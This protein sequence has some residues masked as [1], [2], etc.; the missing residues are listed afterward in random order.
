MV[1]CSSNRTMVWSSLC[2]DDSSNALL[3]IFVTSRPSLS[4]LLLHLFLFLAPLSVVSLL[5]AK[6]LVPL[7]KST[8]FWFAWFDNSSL[9][10]HALAVCVHP[11]LKHTFLLIPKWSTVSWKWSLVTYIQ[12]IISVKIVLVY[13]TERDSHTIDHDA[14]RISHVGSDGQ[15]TGW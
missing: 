5:S 8:Y 3:I 4:C 11:W 1:W 14:S 13:F 2:L 10:F 15:V 9:L 7:L 6:M 12:Y